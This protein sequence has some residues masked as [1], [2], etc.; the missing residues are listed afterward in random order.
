ME[1]HIPIPAEWINRIVE[2]LF[3]DH[4]QGGDA[5]EILPCR[6]W[7]KLILRDE[8]QIVLC[9]W[10]SEGNPW[11]DNSDRVVLVRS[12]VTA[13]KLLKCSND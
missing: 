4:C 1:N 6:V 13:I 5:K 2:I 3:W 7:G 12:A 11:D 8:K 9:Q 10:E